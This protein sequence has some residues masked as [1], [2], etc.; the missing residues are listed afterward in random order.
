MASYIT[1]LQEKVKKIEDA[2]K[3]KQKEQ[4]R[5]KI[6][7]RW[8][9]VLGKVNIGQKLKGLGMSKGSGGG[10]GGLLKNLKK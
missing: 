8:G 6:K 10:L 1:K 5:K 9:K 2:A 4:D 3:K 7:K